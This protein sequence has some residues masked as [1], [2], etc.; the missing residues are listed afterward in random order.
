MLTW[1]LFFK[2]RYPRY[3]KKKKKISYGKKSERNKKINL[4]ENVSFSKV[5]QYVKNIFVLRSL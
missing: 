1:N 4:L 5:E 2:N 3:Q